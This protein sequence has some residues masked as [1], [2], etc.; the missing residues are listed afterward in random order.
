MGSTNNKVEYNFERSL[1][2]I[3]HALDM[4]VSFC[5][6]FDGT[7]MIPTILPNAKIKLFNTTSLE[8][9]NIYVYIDINSPTKRLVCHRL[10][11]IADDLCYF[12]GDN[13][14]EIDPPVAMEMVIA[15][16][17]L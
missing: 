16:V 6:S 14:K 11:A 4:G 8:L 12:K 3:S 9:N 2:V 15:E 5:F 7:S 1:E 13:R 17:V 10:I